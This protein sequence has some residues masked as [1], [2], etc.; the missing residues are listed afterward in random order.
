[1]V[2]NISWVE[3]VVI[4]PVDRTDLPA[5]E[6]DGEYT[7]FRRVYADAYERTKHGRTLLWLADLQGKL[8]G[9]IFVQIMSD[10]PDL[11]DGL[12]RAYVY[13]FRVRPPYRGAGLGTRMMQFV[14]EDLAQRGIHLVTLNVAQDNPG[15]RRL[16]ER[17]GYAVVGAD[18]GRWSYPDHEGAWHTIEEPAW[19]MEKLIA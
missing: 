19:R 13:S 15:A 11:I 5:M 16:Y 18:P 6:W 1:V 14:E 8:I 10:S 17:L 3:Q 2:E 7:H 12:R 4:R 9:Q